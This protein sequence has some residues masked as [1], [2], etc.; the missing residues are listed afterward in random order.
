MLILVLLI[1][2]VM[3]VV[4]YDGND[5]SPGEVSD[6]FTDIGKKCPSYDK[7]A[8]NFY[9]RAQ[10]TLGQSSQFRFED[11]EWVDKN[12]ETYAGSKPLWFYSS[13][14]SIDLEWEY[15]GSE[16]KISVYLGEAD[17][18]ALG[19]QSEWYIQI[20]TDINNQEKV[21]CQNVWSKTTDEP[22]YWTAT[23][24]YETFGGEPREW[25]LEGVI[26]AV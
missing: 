16:K 15:M 19:T 7:M 12:T 4:F 25:T 13:D 23:L 26:T 9:V 3:F 18:G 10:K 24:H 2:G 20:V 22:V 17:I 21:E 14:Y 5:L 8:L 6:I 11:A 1:L